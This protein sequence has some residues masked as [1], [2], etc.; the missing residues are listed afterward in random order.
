MIEPT[1]ASPVEVR[2]QR[3]QEQITI[4]WDDDHVSVYPL[5][6]IRGYCPCAHCQGHSGTWTFVEGDPH[7]QVESIGEVGHYALNI[8]YVGG[9]KTGIYSFDVL[10]QLCPCDACVAR[11]GSEHPFLVSTHQR[12]L[13]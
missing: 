5:W 4:Q 8:A 3:A 1:T 11:V 13:A 6:Y 12:V 2:L 7:P 9:H 10:R